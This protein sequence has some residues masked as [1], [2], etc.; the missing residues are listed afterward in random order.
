MG[1]KRMKAWVQLLRGPTVFPNFP[2]R[3]G[4]CSGFLFDWL[5]SCLVQFILAQPLFYA[6]VVRL[7][8]GHSAGLSFMWTR[9]SS[10]TH[11]RWGSHASVSFCLAV[12]G[13]R[14]GE[15]LMRLSSSGAAF[16]V[17]EAEGAHIAV[18]GGH[19]RRLLLA[20]GLDC[21]ARLSL[22][23][24]YL[25]SLCSRSPRPILLLIILSSPYLLLTRS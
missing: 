11:S 21:V 1:I 16:L 3:F 8:T 17:K 23:L 7:G 20:F 10:C 22:R 13:A 12:T 25:P 15:V 19:V 24:S 5:L 6:S 2:I 9:F 14:R 18:Y 4:S